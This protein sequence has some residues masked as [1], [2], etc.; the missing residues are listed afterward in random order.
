MNSTS[1]RYPTLSLALSSFNTRHFDSAPT[2]TRRL[3]RMASVPY[4][5]L[6]EILKWLIE[7]EQD[8]I[9]KSEALSPFEVI[10]GVQPSRG[11]HG[12]IYLRA[13]CLV[14]KWWRVVA[15]PILQA[16]LCWSTS[17][18]KTAVENLLKID[19]M[20][21]KVTSIEAGKTFCETCE[22]CNPGGPCSCGI[23]IETV[24]TI[25]PTCPRLNRLVVNKWSGIDVASSIPSTPISTLPQ[26]TTLCIGSNNRLSLR[27]FCLIL[28][29]MPAL[30]TLSIDD[31]RNTSNDTIDD[32][33][34][35]PCRLRSFVVWDARDIEFD[36]LFH[37]SKDSL[38]IFNMYSNSPRNTVSFFRS[39]AHIGP[40]LRIFRCL[41]CWDSQVVLFALQHC[42]KLEALACCS[43]LDILDDLANA[44]C[45]N[46]LRR[47]TAAK[48]IRTVE[49]RSKEWVIMF[50]SSEVLARMRQVVQKGVLP[51]LK[52]CRLLTWAKERLVA[53]PKD[54][55]IA[56]KN[57]CDRHGVVFDFARFDEAIS[58]DQEVWS[59]C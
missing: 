21:S 51:Q 25:L 37:N 53:V 16:H 44:A 5:V 9:S 2:P 8:E 18:G 34:Y 50:W 4:D 40:S 38:R 47:F 19:G 32:I 3:E 28:Q 36:W 17:A 29:L 6:V 59:E 14:S 54:E 13:C 12:R 42:H 31:I 26:L 58:S 56:L 10:Y 22:T 49:R 48:V 30:H 24:I 27:T 57:E 1:G 33:P 55:L 35:P 20:A 52:E 41:G 46:T 43:G 11:S 39:L 7:P 15:Q 45:A 23:S